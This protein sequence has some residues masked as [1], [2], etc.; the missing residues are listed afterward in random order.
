MSQADLLSPAFY[1]NSLSCDPEVFD[2]ALHALLP[3][4]AAAGSGGGN[5]DDG[6]AASRRLLASLAAWVPIT[7]VVAIP[8]AVAYLLLFKCVKAAG[9]DNLMDSKLESGLGKD[10]NK[11]A[12]CML[13][14]ATPPHPLN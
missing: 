6:A 14:W 9:R 3:S 4:P 12:S 11:L 7:V 10:K 13:P 1:N 2:A 5:G 8:M